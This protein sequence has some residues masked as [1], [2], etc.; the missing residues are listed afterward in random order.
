MPQPGVGIPET[1]T[2]MAR[3][4]APYATEMGAA[5]GRTLP[6]VGA[7]GAGA[8]A[9]APIL[10]MPSNTGA[11]TIDLGDGLRASM[12]PGQRYVPIER[13]VAPGVFGSDTG[14]TWKQVPGLYAEVNPGKG[15]LVDPDQLREALG[16]EAANRILSMPGI[17]PMA[18][19]P[20][21]K[22][23]IGPGH[24]LPRSDNSPGG[25]SGG[26]DAATAIALGAVAAATEIATDPIRGANILRNAERGRQFQKD[27]LA[28][29]EIP[30][31]KER[32]RVTIDDGK[33][34]TVIPDA[35]STTLITEAK[36]VVNLSNSDQFRGYFATRRPINLIVSPNTKTISE[37][38]QK[39]ID[40]SG[41][42]IRVFDP[43]TRTFTPWN[44]R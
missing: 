3:R 13:R 40:A 35:Q 32:I 44:L 42:S 20:P 43:T 28:A 36:D 9:A 14:A 10:L 6:S 30:E 25:P 22:R 33:L 24:N 21:D 1:L 16:E 37:P 31:N 41:G 7:A 39:L 4:L 19:Q 23:P 8:L 17:M 15:L 27:V 29:L 2:Q 12:P 26:P 38:L 11:T 18:Q 5:I 34:V